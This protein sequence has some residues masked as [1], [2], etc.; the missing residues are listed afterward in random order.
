ML[1]RNENHGDIPAIG[2]IVTEALDRLLG[3]MDNL[4]SLAAQVKRQ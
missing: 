1:I 4:K 3:D 2:R